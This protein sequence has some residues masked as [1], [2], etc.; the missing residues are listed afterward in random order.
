MLHVIHN[1]RFVPAVVFF[2][3]VHKFRRVNFAL[4]SGVGFE[5]AVHSG[6]EVRDRIPERFVVPFWGY[7]GRAVEIVHGV[8]D[9]F[10]FFSVGHSV[11]PWLV[12]GTSTVV[13]A[14][15]VLPVLVGRGAF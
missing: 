7:V 2:L 15:L 5:V 10:D 8:V 4:L 14:P 3:A 13:G 12:V 1:L 11:S 9:R 6:G